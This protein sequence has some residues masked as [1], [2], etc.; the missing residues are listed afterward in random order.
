M[1]M[2][3]KRGAKYDTSIRIRCSWTWRHRLDTLLEKLGL[4]LASYIRARV[5]RDFF[6]HKL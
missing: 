3:H 1:A 6:Q 5:E 2:K 4:T